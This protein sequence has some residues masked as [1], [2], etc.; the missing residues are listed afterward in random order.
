V[1]IL[2][3]DKDFAGIEKFIYGKNY[4]S[5][6]ERV[7]SQFGSIV[8]ELGEDFLVSTLS[9]NFSSPRLNVHAALHTVSSPIMALSH[10]KQIND[11]AYSE[12]R[13]LS[14]DRPLSPTTEQHVRAKSTESHI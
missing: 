8:S 6:L 5:V 9:R 14:P 2:V 12:G 11:D 4:L 7:I 1:K 13:D 10:R 3:E